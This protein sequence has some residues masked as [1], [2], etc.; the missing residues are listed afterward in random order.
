[1]ARLQT[2]I[3]K[4]H[5]EKKAWAEG[6]YACGLD[7]V[8][9]GCLA[10][11]LVVCAVIIPQNVSHPLLK[12]SKVLS[13]EERNRAF[14]WITKHCFYSTSI[15]SNRVI[16]S[17]NIY[18]ATLVGMKKAYL[19][20]IETLPFP[21]TQLKYVVIDAMPLSLDT[22]YG[23]D[24][25]EW[26]HFNK[27]ESLSTSIAAASIVAKVTR[28]MLMA[29]LI[30]PQ[31]PEFNFGQHKGYA[32]KQHTDVLIAQGPSTVHRSSFIR[33]IMSNKVVEKQLQ[34]NLF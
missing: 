7:E 1:M 13:P 14:E 4:N 6:S 20:L 23:H 33:G 12:D 31:F 8:G 18:Q 26:Y 34:K 25:L 17:I 22:I 24:D 9:R 5:F 28:D 19:G 32:T 3:L 21:L 11:P 29:N 15:L 16:D 30:G 2:K 10:G 27:G